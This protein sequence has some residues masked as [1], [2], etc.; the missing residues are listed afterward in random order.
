M[1]SDQAQYRVIAIVDRAFGDKLKTIPTGVPVWIID[2]SVNRAA[3]KEVWDTAPLVSHLEGITV[4]KSPDDASPER[5]LIG[6]IDAI[7]LHHGF[8]SADPPY[9]VL[10]V[11]GAAVTQEIRAA[12]DQIGFSEIQPLEE[13]FRVFR[14]S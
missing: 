13:G 6:Q 11:I 14:K 5:S 10:D 1:N 8:Y 9:S 12:L 3:A 7:D 4:F 2:S